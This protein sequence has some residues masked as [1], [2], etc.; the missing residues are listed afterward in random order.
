MPHG[1]TK[2]ERKVLGM[3]EIESW[4]RD[5]TEKLTECFGGR[6]LFVGLQGSYRRKEATPASD[7]DCVVVLDELGMDDLACYKALIATM[8]EAENACG[9]VA[10]K[11]QMQNWPRHEIFQFVQDTRPYYGSLEGLVLATSREDVVQGVA[12]GAANLYH[13]CGHAYL[14]GLQSEWEAH[15][16]SLYKGAFFVLQSLHY[17]RKGVYAGSKRQLLLLLDG[18]EKEILQ[19]GMEWSEAGTA[20]PED[21]L[22]YFEKMMVW[23]GGILAQ[24]L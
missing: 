5:M 14:H 20:Q 21:L 8:P 12:V 6:L 22:P 7:I 24:E 17:L 18:T 11:Q 2:T 4:M 1:E 10:G 13:A 23:C 3:V 19:T 9:F 16:R 15:L